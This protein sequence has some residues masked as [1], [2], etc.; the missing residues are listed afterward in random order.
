MP[1]IV[2]KCELG[3]ISQME[4]TDKNPSGGTA[5]KVWTT[6]DLER[7]GTIA[8]VAGAPIPGTQAANGKKS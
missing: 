3:Y 4:H 8:D 1:R 6:P 5:A 7:I 2:L